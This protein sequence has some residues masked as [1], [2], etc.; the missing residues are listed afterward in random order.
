MEKIFIDSSADI[1]KKALIAW[2]TFWHPKSAGGFTMQTLVKYLLE[3]RQTLGDLDSYILSTYGVHSKQA[4]WM[5]KRKAYMNF[6]EAGIQ[7][8]DGLIME[9]QS[10]SLSCSGIAHEITYQVQNEVNRALTHMKGK[11]SNVQGYRMHD[12]SWC[13]VLWV[14]GK[15]LSTI[16]REGTEYCSDY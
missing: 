4:S 14:A 15:K 11:N 10:G 13:C 12:Y 8:D 7:E 3:E 16:S 5:S 2:D 1:T 9:L 6:T